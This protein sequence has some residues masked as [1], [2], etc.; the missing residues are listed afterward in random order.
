MRLPM[1][2]TCARARLLPCVL[3]LVSAIALPARAQQAESPPPPAAPQPAPD[4]APPGGEPTAAEPA[5]P[6]PDVAPPESQPGEQAEPTS[7]PA[8]EPPAAEPAEPAPAVAAPAPQ[9]GE[10]DELMDEDATA[11]LRMQQVDARRKAELTRALR[12]VQREE[13]DSS[14]LL[15]L[16]VTGMGITL[17]LTGVAVG[18]SEVLRCDDSCT[19]P[20]WPAWFV[21]GGGTVATAGGIWLARTDHDIAQLHSK[22]FQI[23]RELQ[24]LE[25]SAGR[26]APAP[27]PGAP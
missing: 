20:F 27:G 23:E 4:A 18:A 16:L 24:Y 17:L 13:Q 10:E 8:V 15:P 25:W 2:P 5:A 9:P 1:A 11:V 7:E 14:R 21:V 3:L 26:A 12:T 6:A 19:M 22:R